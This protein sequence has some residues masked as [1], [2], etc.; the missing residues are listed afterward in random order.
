MVVILVAYLVKI[1]RKDLLPDVWLG[2]ALAA[3]LSLGFGALLTYGTRGLTLEAQEA[4]GGSLPSSP[5]ASSPGWCS[6]WPGPRRTCAESCTAGWTAISPVVARVSWWWPSQARVVR[7]RFR[8]SPRRA[9]PAMTRASAVPDAT[10]VPPWS[11]A[12][13]RT[14]VDRRRSP[15]RD[16][17]PWCHPQLRVRR[18]RTPDEHQLLRRHRRNDLH[19]QR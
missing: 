9:G 5:S 15:D 3:A 18:P 11:T 1:H 17:W 16:Q 13:S 12:P 7:R 2:V 19:V 14:P 10:A 6:G 4:I 8:G